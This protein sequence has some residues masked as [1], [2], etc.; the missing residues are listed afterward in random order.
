MTLERI[1]YKKK[2]KL[3]TYRK[4]KNIFKLEP[5][6]FHSNKQER[7]IL[8]KFRISSHTLN[9]E[10]GRYL[11]LKQEERICNLCNSDIEDEQ[12]FLVKCPSLEIY[13]LP[14][15]TLLQKHCKMFLSLNDE[16]KLVWLMSSEDK[17]VISV[18]AKLL[19]AL[20]E[21]RSKILNLNGVASPAP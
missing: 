5:Y 1:L 20:F 4:F 14:S 18:V 11:G 21:E 6:L 19:I 10:R 9:I 15:F 17:C 2:N 12:H 16:Q 7:Q 13:R 8:T 3:R